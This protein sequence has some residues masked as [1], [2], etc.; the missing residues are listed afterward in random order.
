MSYVEN[1]VRIHHGVELFQEHLHIS[2][3]LVDLDNIESRF[4]LVCPLLVKSLQ[5]LLL[6]PAVFGEASS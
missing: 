4:D 1:G 6:G 2:L 5:F 3:V